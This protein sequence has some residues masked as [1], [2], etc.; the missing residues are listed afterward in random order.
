MPAAAGPRRRRTSTE[1]PRAVASTA[2]AAAPTAAKGACPGLSRSG[3]TV[4]GGSATSN[5]RGSVRVA[6]AFARVPAAARGATPARGRWDAAPTT[7]GTG[8]AIVAPAATRPPSV[9]LARVTSRTPGLACPADVRVLASS[10][11]PASAPGAEDR[12]VVR[13]GRAERGWTESGRVPS[14]CES[15]GSAGV[16]AAVGGAA[17]G[18]TAGAGAACG[19]GSLTAAGA[20]GAASGGGRKSSGSR[21]P[22]GSALR[23]MP[24]YTYGTASS[25]TPLGPTVPTRSRSATVAPRRTSYEPRCTSVTAYPSCVW[26]VTVLPPV[27]TTPAKETV[28][29]AGAST[30]VPLGAPMS[31][32][33]CCPAAYGSLPNA[34]GRKTGPW[35]GQ[36]HAR[37][38]AGDTT[39]ASNAH[40]TSRR[41]SPVLVAR[42]EN[43]N[44]KVARLGARC[45]I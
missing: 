27:G 10:A 6:S 19:A 15:T 22:C 30:G 45:Q 40:A 2:I 1:S 14:G 34:N 23:R 38:D 8:A 24:R 43:T 28:P 9:L 18:A 17:A 26:I 33:R 12:G 44:P 37:P 39:A 21:Y 4:L 7:T 20:T 35:T 5:C 32:P 31:M 3:E 42:C 13:P 36:L 11:A 25:A 29:L 16:D 41:R